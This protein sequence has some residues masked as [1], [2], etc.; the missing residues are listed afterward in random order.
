MSKIIDHE[1][2]KAERLR[3]QKRDYMRRTR[4]QS[5]EKIKKW[6]KCRTK[7]QDKVNKDR[8]YLQNIDHVSKYNREYQETNK[9]KISDQRKAKY[10][11]DPEKEIAIV[12]EWQRR[13][14][15]KVREYRVKNKHK[16]LANTR[17]RQL[18]IKN[19]TPINADR[20]IIAKIYLRSRILSELTHIPHEVDHIFP[21]AKGGLHH[22]DN[23]Q[24]LTRAEN[25]SKGIKITNIKGVTI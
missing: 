25:R 5:S 22:Q 15:H 2:D 9:T 24:I 12:K 1:T 8:W 10:W 3:K 20:L 4:L 18:R 19:Q 7:E 11:T 23:L 16:I 21:L 17:Y 13:N 6:N 14:L